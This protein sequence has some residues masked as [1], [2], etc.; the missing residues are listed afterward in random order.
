L[1]NR[2]A[3]R[4]DIGNRRSLR[5][6]FRLQNRLNSLINR[7]FIAAIAPLRFEMTHQSFVRQVFQQ[8]RKTVNPLNFQFLPPP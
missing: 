8:Q 2:T 1:L 6:D 3:V 7:D 5:E 4:R